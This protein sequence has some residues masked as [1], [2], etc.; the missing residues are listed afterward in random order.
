MK[1]GSI[2]CTLIFVAGMLLSLLQLWFE[3]FSAELFIK[4]LITLSV[5]FVVAL[6][7]TLVV[8]EYI[9][10]REMKKQGYID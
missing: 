10:E 3:P 2:V 9:S 5:L 1:V 4:L 6:A 7:I 8:R